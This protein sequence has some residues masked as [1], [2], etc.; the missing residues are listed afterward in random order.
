MLQK[1]V[2]YFVTICTLLK[3][4]LVHLVIEQLEYI[5][6]QRF[7]H[8]GIVFPDFI[9]E[10]CQV[11]LLAILSFST[12]SGLDKMVKLFLDVLVIDDILLYDLINFILVYIVDVRL[13]QVRLLIEVQ[14][15]KQTILVFIVRVNLTLFYFF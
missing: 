13:D 11:K 5:I 6:F 12:R 2:P 8:V 4:Q 10:S 1:L 7:R 14:F 15:P 9:R 3:L